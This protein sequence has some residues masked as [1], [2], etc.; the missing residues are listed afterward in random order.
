MDAEE[1][2]AGDGL[3]GRFVDNVF[4]NPAM[5]GGLLVMALTAAS[6]VS[7]AVFLQSSRHPEPFFNTRPAETRRAPPP[8]AV[9][10]IPP[11][12]VAPPVEAPPVRPEP[13]A[14]VPAAAPAHAP[15]AAVPDPQKKLVR[16]IQ[17]QLAASGYY[18]GAV[19]G[20]VGSRT[21]AA[22]AADQKAS[23]LPV[24]GEPSTAL[25][26][27]M[28]APPPAVKPKAVERAP[29]AL[30]PETVPPKTGTAATAAPEAT[31]SIGD[32]IPDTSSAAVESAAAKPAAEAAKPDTAKAGR[33]RYRRVQDALNQ[34]GYGPLT[35]SGKGDAATEEAIRR[36][37][38]DNGMPLTGE[39]SDRLV[40][41]LIAIG[42]MAPT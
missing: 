25:L 34:I 4:A 11:S 13:A 5:S 21:K 6:I 35:A 37:E 27:Q 33:D 22:I 10:P 8:A 30:P 31:G 39:V 36:F 3:V 17:I 16:D 15:A 2:I 9:V 14:S 18:S 28:S 24:T 7:N 32:L 42:A 20:I 41:R 29:A 12:R 38:L 19:D 40:N 1:A 26:E 23:A